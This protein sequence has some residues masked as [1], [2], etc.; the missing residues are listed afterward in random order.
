MQRIVNRWKQLLIDSRP[1]TPGIKPS[2][3][4]TSSYNGNN[5][6]VDVPGVQITLDPNLLSPLV[7]DLDTYVEAHPHRID[8]ALLKRAKS[9]IKSMDPPADVG[10]QG[11]ASDRFL[12]YIARPVIKLAQALGIGN[13][14]INTLELLNGVKPDRVFKVDGQCA[15]IVEYKNPTSGSTHSPQLYEEANDPEGINLDLREDNTESTSILS[16][17]RRSGL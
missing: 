4:T 5:K 9:F 12:E 7:G 14:T 15:L 2:G 6:P 3:N 8:A 16:K 10:S 17:V 13:P 1:A 11:E